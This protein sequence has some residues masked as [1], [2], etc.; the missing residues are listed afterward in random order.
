MD[1]RIGYHT[2]IAEYPIWINTL[3]TGEAIKTA[4]QLIY[5]FTRSEMMDGRWMREDFTNWKKSTSP[6]DFTRS[7]WAWMQRNVPVRP[8]PSLQ[9]ATQMA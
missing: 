2:W 9:G 5:Q 3:G 1:I 7:S 6:S 8:I 4:L